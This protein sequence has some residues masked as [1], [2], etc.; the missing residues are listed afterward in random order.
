MTALSAASR[1]QDLQRLFDSAL[2]Q[3]AADRNAWIDAQTDDAELRVELRKLLEH[4]AT[5]GEWTAGFQLEAARIGAVAAEAPD[6]YGG[7][8]LLSLAGNGGMGSVYLAQRAFAGGTQRAA[9][10]ISHALLPDAESAR[11]LRAE[12]ALLATIRHHGIAR[13]IDAGETAEGRPWFAMEWVDGEPL[14]RAFTQRRLPVRARIE[15]F[16]RI[17]AALS[18][19]HQR[20]VLH[21]DI[22]SSN[23]LLDATG[24]PH[25]VD[26]G[27]AK[28]LS[29]DSA[30]AT[31]ASARFFTAHSA[32]PEQVTGG[33]PTTAVDVYGVGA[34]LYEALTGRP[35][36]SLDG[37]RSPA[38]VARIVQEAAPQA[39][40]RAIASATHGPDAT[41]RDAALA[42][43]R[44]CGLRDAGALARML[45]GDLDRIVLHCLRKDPSERYHTIDDLDAD[46][47]RWLEGRPVTAA[48]QSFWY[49]TRKLAWRHRVPL[50]AGATVFAALSALSASLAL[51]GIELRAERDRARH[52][53]QRSELERK[54]ADATTEFLVDA[55]QRADPR[56]AGSP[57]IDR[58]EMVDSAM[59]RLE[60]GSI[61]DPAILG[62]L[63]VALADVAQATGHREALGRAVALYGRA[64]LGAGPPTAREQLELAL[65]AGRDAANARDNATRAALLAV[66]EAARESSAVADPDLDFWLRSQQAAYRFEIGERDAALAI[67]VALRGHVPTGPRQAE[68]TLRLETRIAG[69]LR[70]LGRPGEAVEALRGALSIALARTDVPE[71]VLVDAKLGMAHSLRQVGR[72]D[73]SLHQLREALP[74][75]R[76]MFGP[77]STNV[78]SIHTAVGA[79]LDALGRHAEAAAEHRAAIGIYV[80]QRG[81]DDS[82][83]LMAE[84]NLLRSRILAEGASMALARDAERIADRATT[85]WGAG[86]PNA[87]VMALQAAQ[88]LHDSGELQAARRRYASIVEQARATGREGVTAAKAAVGVAVVD[89]ALGDAAIDVAR[90]DDALSRVGSAEAHDDALVTAGRALR[91]ALASHAPPT[92]DPLQ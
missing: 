7:W 44:A 12:R 28:L 15:T 68:R 62:R 65:I 26:F 20:L 14:L 86:H 50:A 83:T 22:K 61:D 51:Q 4:H 3:P 73:E 43:A 33:A 1:W 37:A 49:R 60:A 45:G 17:C 69:A 71:N 31:E 25:I 77:S 11:R 36:L 70:A 64:A 21:R 67:W 74:A 91:Q 35:P 59:Q 85:R 81:P 80:A 78:A 8:T 41:T 46:L 18:H 34:L 53:Q 75:A 42:H 52:E 5:T 40:S 88:A 92:T 30:D 6:A 56:R 84:Y 19:A 87:Q 72:H 76:D 10:K 57:T 58:R 38:D 29:S 54:R 9:L 47:G 79:T 66:A 27:I 55:F 24:A 23:V 63:A 2:S 16:R 82:G 39:P 90:L 13:L 32:A 48:G 89:V